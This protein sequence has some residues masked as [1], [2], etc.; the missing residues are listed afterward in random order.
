MNVSH[1]QRIEEGNVIVEIDKMN[2]KKECK[3]CQDD[4]IG[5]IISQK[6]DKPYTTKELNAK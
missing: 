3:E 6:G 1:P 4:V 2:Y 5:R